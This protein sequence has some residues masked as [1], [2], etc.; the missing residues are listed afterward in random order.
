V[1]VSIERL[2]CCEICFDL[3]WSTYRWCIARWRPG[4]HLG[5]AYTLSPDHRV[6]Q[7]HNWMPSRG[8]VLSRPDEQVARR[9]SAECT[10]CSGSKT[11]HANRP[12]N[13]PRGQWGHEPCGWWSAAQGVDLR[14]GGCTVCGVSLKR[15]HITASAMCDGFVPETCCFVKSARYLSASATMHTAT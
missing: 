10:E 15:A 7:S 9:F 8:L 6:G 5:Q 14:R 2:C 4:A 1:E 11:A 3:L 13:A 12:S